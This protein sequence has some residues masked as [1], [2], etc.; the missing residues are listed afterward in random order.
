[1][2]EIPSMIQQLG[3]PSDVPFGGQVYKLGPPSQKAKAI[4]EE[5]VAV[6]AVTGL[7]KLQH[8]LPPDRF[9]RMESVIS[10]Q[11]AAE[12]HATGGELWGEVLG[13]PA[14]STLFT[15]SLFRVNHPE[16]T[17][18]QCEEISAGASVELSAALVR[19]VPGFFEQAFPKMPP[20]ER[21]K[22]VAAMVDDL[23]KVRQWSTAAT[24][25]DSTAS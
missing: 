16:M 21:A 24:P 25:P 6:Q 14:G 23:E 5:L 15:L 13:T 19:Q 12:E 20:A 1:M 4:L 2:D 10:R 7:S 11:L 22:R 9:R 18:E 8:V 3:L 17:R